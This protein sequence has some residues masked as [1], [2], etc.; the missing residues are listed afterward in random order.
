MP[1][2]SMRTLAIVIALRPGLV[3]AQQH[4]EATSMDWTAVFTGLLVLA[5]VL[6]VVV[7]GGLVWVAWRQLQDAHVLQRAASSASRA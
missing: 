5:T 2:S 3:A 1:I 7:T 4:T 6:L